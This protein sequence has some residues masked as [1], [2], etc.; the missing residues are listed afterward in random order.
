MFYYKI[1]KILNDY[2]LVFIRYRNKNIF[3]NIY[4]IRLQKYYSVV[5]NRYFVLYYIFYIKNAKLIYIVLNKK[6]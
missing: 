5:I 6:L 1:I 3:F 4:L 2:G